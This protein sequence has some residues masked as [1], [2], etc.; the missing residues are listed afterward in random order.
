MSRTIRR[1]EKYLI[2]NVIGGNDYYGQPYHPPRYEHLP[3]AM[4][5][6][7]QR[8]RYTRDRHS[9]T[10]NCPRWWRKLYYVDPERRMAKL[11]IHR[12][13]RQG[14]FDDHLDPRLR[15]AN[16]QWHWWMT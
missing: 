3:Y 12:C 9:G 4:A 1:N 7:R 15:G 6:Q 5:I 11:E 16:W 10:Y 13:L 8:A 14:D 2:K